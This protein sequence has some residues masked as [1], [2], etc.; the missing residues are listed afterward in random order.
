M[1]VNEVR[2][3]I[4][5]TAHTRQM[6]AVSLALALT[7]LLPGCTS[8]QNPANLSSTAKVVFTPKDYQDVMWDSIMARFPDA[9][10]PEVPIVRVITDEDF[11]PLYEQCMHEEGFEVEVY[12]DTGFK[13]FVPEGQ[14]EPFSLAMYICEAKYPRPTEMGV[15]EDDASGHLLYSYYRDSLIQCL[16]DQGFEPEPLPSETKFLDAMSTDERYDPYAGLLRT[17]GLNFSDWETLNEECPQRP[18][19]LE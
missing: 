14:D 6:L 13:A 4:G 7:L 16:T 5:R 12:E 3:H 19:E 15:A 17:G 11:A 1:S 2:Q 8:Q 10:R 18:A 9:V